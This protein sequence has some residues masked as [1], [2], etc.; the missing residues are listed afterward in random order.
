MFFLSSSYT[1][2]WSAIHFF[3]S[4]FFSED[5][6][7]LTFIPLYIINVVLSYSVYNNSKLEPSAG[8]FL[9]V[10]A[11]FFPCV[12]GYL[13]FFFF[14]HLYWSIIASQWCVSFC[15]I[16]KWISYRYTHVPIS[17]PGY[18]L[19]HSSYLFEK[20]FV[21]NIW[22]L[23]WMFLLLKRISICCWSGVQYLPGIHILLD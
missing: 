21:E 8:V 18:L 22:S 12:P 16:T 13:F 4:I 23:V 15:F 17:P 11:H 10:L 1:Y 7:N 3:H 14:K 5:V 2:F 9:L 6:S 19:S 20:S